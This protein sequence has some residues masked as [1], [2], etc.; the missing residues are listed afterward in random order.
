MRLRKTTVG[1][2]QQRLH[3]LCFA[4]N[5]ALFVVACRSLREVL[6]LRITDKGLMK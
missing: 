3:C 2:V 4:H 1:F 5:E 6:L